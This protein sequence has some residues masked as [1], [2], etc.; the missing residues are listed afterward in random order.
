MTRSSVLEDGPD[1]AFGEAP[2][3][4]SGVPATEPVAAEPEPARRPRAQRR[5]ALERRDEF[6]TRAAA[7]F[8]EQGFHGSTRA[9]ADQLGVK[10]ALLYRYFD[11]KEALVAAVFA[12][13]FSERWSDDFAA[14]LA[15]RERALEDRLAEV[16]RAYA[17][18]D[19]ALALRLVLRAALDNHP[20]PQGRGAPVTEQIV[21]PL[22]AELR[23]EARLPGLDRQPLL[24]AERD[25]AMMLHAA[26]VFH[27]IRQHVYR[28]P[29]APERD[30]VVNLYCQTFLAGAR[31]QIRRIHRRPPLSAPLASSSLARPA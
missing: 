30:E 17:A 11:S 20:V 2:A 25:M 13:V 22:V 19:H 10:Q 1:E 9:L 16:Y 28:L 24:K 26:V 18:R 8:A 29:V 12:R 27:G 23:H 14:I 21:A 5:P 4:V 31:E 7:F 3:S 15:D 6:I